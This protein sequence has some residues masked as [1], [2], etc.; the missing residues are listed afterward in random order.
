M[1]THSRSNFE[2]SPLQRSLVETIDMFNREDYL[3]SSFLGHPYSIWD[4]PVANI[5]PIHQ[6]SAYN[7]EKNLHEFINNNKLFA[8]NNDTNIFGPNQSIFSIQENTSLVSEATRHLIEQLFDSVDL[9]ITDLFN[10]VQHPADISSSDIVLG[11]SSISLSTTDSSTIHSRRSSYDLDETQLKS[12]LLVEDLVDQYVDSEST[13]EEFALK[14]PQTTSVILD[15]NTSLQL[16]YNSNEAKDITLK[17]G[18]RSALPKV[19]PD[20]SPLNKA[21]ICKLKHLQTREPDNT[22]CEDNIRE[23][24]K[25]SFHFIPSEECDNRIKSSL[26]FKYAERHDYKISRFHTQ[27][28]SLDKY[29]LNR[30][31]HQYKKNHKFSF[32]LPFE[33]E[34]YKIALDEQGQPETD[35][36]SGLCPCCPNPLFFNMKNGSY[37]HHLSTVHGIYSDHY[38]TPEPFIVGKFRVKMSGADKKKKGRATVNSGSDGVICPMCHSIVEIDTTAPKER[39]MV[40]YLRHFESEHR[41]KAFRTSI[42]TKSKVKNP[43]TDTTQTKINDYIF[44][45]D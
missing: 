42:T 26:I 35:S 15:E 41:V 19:T 44:E 25:N 30:E 45:V 38:L 12:F 28:Y 36:E 3:S 1:T 4:A 40:K 43:T 7:L 20:N 11:G 27:R 31:C 13:D 17:K 34:F 39:V 6:F 23:L 9:R 16:F 18:E 21:F 33:P 37:F 24:S 5:S 2:N 29:N 10:E 14:E 32:E 8:T 22:C